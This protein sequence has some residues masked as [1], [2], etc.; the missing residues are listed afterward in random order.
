MNK[1]FTLFD[2]V[3][4][5]HNPK[6]NVADENL[7]HLQSLK[8]PRT[9]GSNT[10]KSLLELLEIHGDRVLTPIDEHDAKLVANGYTA[11]FIELSSNEQQFM[12]SRMNCATLENYDSS[13]EGED[14]I[15]A[16]KGLH[17]WEL[18]LEIPCPIDIPCYRIYFI[19]SDSKNCL[20]TWHPGKP[21]RMLPQDCAVKLR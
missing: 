18:V 4:H 21:L 14:R 6:A 17:G 5:I 12:N 1:P 11:W 13:D 8:G 3:D 15:V 19:W 20:A 9:R 10:D 16:R 2:I 7:P